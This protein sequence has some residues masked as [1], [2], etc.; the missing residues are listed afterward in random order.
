M[1]LLS[2]KTVSEKESMS[3]HQTVLRTGTAQKDYQV[4]AVEDSPCSSST[5][6]NSP[7]ERGSV[8]ANL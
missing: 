4:F 1:P 6:V 5:R 8:N 3:T 7:K 2:F